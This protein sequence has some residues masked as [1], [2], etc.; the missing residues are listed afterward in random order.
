[1]GKVRE[2]LREVREDPPAEIWGKSIP[3]CVNSQCKGPELRVCLED[4]IVGE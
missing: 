1:M 3:D 4:S 2:G